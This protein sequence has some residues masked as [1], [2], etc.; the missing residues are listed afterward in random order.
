[1]TAWLDELTAS[2]GLPEKLFVIHQF[3]AAM[4]QDRPAIVD[5][6]NLA[7]TFHIDGFGTQAQKIAKF[8]QLHPEDPFDYGLKLFIDEDTRMF[9]PSEVRALDPRPDL[10]THQ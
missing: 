3:T 2:N 5:R 7:T 1:M 4:V 6:P 8:D 10:V 9:T